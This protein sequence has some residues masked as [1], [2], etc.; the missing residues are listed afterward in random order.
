MTIPVVEEP[1]HVSG[2]YPRID[3]RRIVLCTNRGDHPPDL[4][5]LMAKVAQ[6][7]DPTWGKYLR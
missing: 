1:L 5:R 4:V 2:L 6:H 3:R 7:K